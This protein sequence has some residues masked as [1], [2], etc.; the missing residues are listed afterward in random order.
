[1]HRDGGRGAVAER[2]GTGRPL[3]VSLNGNG[4]SAYR[5]GSVTS[6]QLGATCGVACGAAGSGD[7]G[8][9]RVGCPDQRSTGG[10]RAGRAGCCGSG[11][12]P[13]VSVSTNDNRGIPLSDQEPNSTSHAQTSKNHPAHGSQLGSQTISRK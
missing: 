3:H 11:H 5:L 8:S 13:V 10:A 6:E 7:V 1:T 12:H 2:T 4:G 9:E